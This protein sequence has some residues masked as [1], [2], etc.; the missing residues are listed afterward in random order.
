M[1]NTRTW[2]LIAGLLLLCLALA[3][4]GGEAPAPITVVVTSAPPDTSAPSD[5]SAPPDTSAP[6]DA[7]T[8]EAPAAGVEILEATFAH[9]LT[10]EM[11]PIDPGSAFDPAETVY[12]SLKLKG[13]PREGIVTA[14]FYYGET[15]IA[16]AD[17]DLAESNSGLIFSFGEDTFLGYTLSHEGVFPA[18]ED[19]RAEVFYGDAPL[20]TY[21]FQVVA[22]AGSLVSRITDALL[23]LDASEDYEPIHPTTIFA[24]DDEVHL[25]GE[26]DLAAGSTLQAEWYVAGQLDEAGTRVLTLEEDIPG[27]GFVFSFLPD[28]GWPPGEHEVALI[29][30]GEEVARFPFGIVDSGGAA[31][32]V[33]PD[34]WDAFPIP[35]DAE[36]VEVV[37]GVDIG[38]ATAM[39]ENHLFD[40][41]RAWLRGQGWEL[42]AA[43]GASGLIQDWSKD[44]AHLHLEVNDIDDQ[45]RAIIW[46]RF[47]AAQ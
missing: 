33:E 15:F 11:Q 25:V 20:A 14:R 23:A 7:A 9:G 30:D 38:F 19:Y 43:Q 5:T 24:F 18:S 31:P 36:G 16:E 3:A 21:P 26:G 46:V 39:D 37:E 6:A 45:G 44:G 40:Y 17:V 8:A 2:R 47:E 34:F 12:L 35:D 42:V 1:T 4:C 13:R 41:Y 29:L 10:E 32:L 28:G 27:A 22:A